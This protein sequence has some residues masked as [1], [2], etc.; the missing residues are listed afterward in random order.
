MPRRKENYTLNM[1]AKSRQKMSPNI[2]NVQQKPPATPNQERND[3]AVDAAIKV[4]IELNK[5]AI[6]ELAKY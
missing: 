4:A 3:R 6:K 5:E 2:G 1:L